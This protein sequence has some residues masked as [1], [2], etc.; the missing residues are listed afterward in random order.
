MADPKKTWSH[1]VE[2]SPRYAQ[3]AGSATMVGGLGFVGYHTLKPVRPAQQGDDDLV[4]HLGEYS[5]RAML[6]Q[7]YLQY[8]GGQ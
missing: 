4:G 3:Y 1:L 7:Q 2:N 8:Q 5:P 6:E